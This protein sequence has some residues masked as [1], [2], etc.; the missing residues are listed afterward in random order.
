M[1]GLDYKIISLHIHKSNYDVLP[2]SSFEDFKEVVLGVSPAGQYD[3]VYNSQEEVVQE[4]LCSRSTDLVFI[5]EKLTSDG[6]STNEKRQQLSTDEYLKE[7]SVE[8]KSER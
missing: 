8:R 7:V 4:G 2:P 5:K 6:C 1:I 3:A